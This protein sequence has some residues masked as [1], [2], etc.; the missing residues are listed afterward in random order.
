MNP[1]TST[2]DPRLPEELVA[3]STFL[4]KRLGFAAKQ[5]AIAAYDEVGLNP[6]HHAV[7]VLLEE[8]GAHETQASIADALGYDRGTMVGLL[9]ELEQQKLIE[10]Q[11]DPQDRRR[12][13]VR[14]TAEGRRGLARLR[15]LAGR[16][17]D[18]FLAPLD[19]AEREALHALL[20]EL[21]ARHE[22]GCTRA[23]G[24]S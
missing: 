10:R 4:L 5:R 9:D 3:S 6:Y 17:E 11:R 24:S 1:Q 12:H 13:I 16:L 8:E 20:L 2:A 7:L 22:P 21:A 15:K 18:D 19:E 14:L 23:R